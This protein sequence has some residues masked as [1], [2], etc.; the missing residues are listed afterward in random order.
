MSAS[1]DTERCIRAKQK[2]AVWRNTAPRISG[3][4]SVAGRRVRV[5]LSS[6]P[7]AGRGL[8]AA[9][10]L[11]RGDLLCRVSGQMMSEE[12]A[13]H[14]AARSTHGDKY[15]LGTSKGVMNVRSAARY[16]NDACGPVRV[17]G[18]R[19]NCRFIEEEDGSV[20]L[21]AT[22]HIRAGEECFVG[23]GRSYWA[24]REATTTED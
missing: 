13:A 6:I 21:E 4:V 24:A 15:F 17:P 16:A 8:F 5:G 22:R 3:E 10:D 2:C 19:N 12:E 7:G 14:F 9:V 1:A 11:R 20:W 23:Y 18:V